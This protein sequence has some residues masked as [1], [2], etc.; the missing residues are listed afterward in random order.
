VKEGQRLTF[1]GLLNKIET[2]TPLNKLMDLQVV[3]ASG[4]Y[5]ELPE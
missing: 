4:T 2:N 3:M 5:Q 1:K